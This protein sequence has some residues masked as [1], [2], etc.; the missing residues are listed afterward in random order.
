MNSRLTEVSNFID[1]NFSKVC[2]RFAALLTGIF[3]VFMTPLTIAY[4]RV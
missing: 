2:C 4:R 3:P 1:F